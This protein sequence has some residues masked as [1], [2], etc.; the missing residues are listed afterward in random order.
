MAG[1]IDLKNVSKTIEET[2]ILEDITFQVKPSECLGIIG[3]NGSGK[4]TLL[5][6]VAG[7]IKP[8]TGRI[9]K[10]NSV[11]KHGIGYSMD[12]S[13]FFPDMSFKNHIKLLYA[14]K[15]KS[16]DRQELAQFEELFQI[17]E[18]F[19]KPFR[20]YSSGMKQKLSIISAF[21]GNPACIILDEP[22]N[23]LDVD[24]V[25]ALKNYIAERETFSPVLLTSHS[26]NHLETVCDRL[27]FLKSGRLIYE[28]LTKQIVDKYASIESAYQQI[29]W[30]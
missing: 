17:D 29:I 18:A 10:N 6:L 3:P 2:M 5:N 19:N 12:I 8:S 9:E 30:T 28:G 7:L 23:G 14:Y 21:I 20:N 11:E 16:V 13:G 22:T 1:I 15:K 4:T 27:I 25:F 26:L 24:A